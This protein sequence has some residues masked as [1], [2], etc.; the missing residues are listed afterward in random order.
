MNILYATTSYFPDLR[1]GTEICTRAL[2]RHVT[3]RGHKA[4]VACGGRTWNSPP[5]HARLGLQ[6]HTYEGVEVSVITSDP[7]RSK[8]GDVYGAWD[9]GRARAW[10][11]VLLD[12]R[13]DLLHQTGTSPVLGVEAVVEGRRLGIPSVW[14]YI[15]GGQTC[16]K[17]A[18]VDAWG[19]G[20]LRR[21]EVSACTRC[22]A[23]WRGG[24]VAGRLIGA[25]GTVLR[26]GSFLQRFGAAGR[27]LG[28]PALLEARFRAWER[29]VGA[30]TKFHAFTRAAAD[31]LITEGVPPAKVLVSFPGLECRDWL[32]PKPHSDGRP[33]DFGFVGRF[34][35]EKGLDVLLRAWEMLPPSA[36][37]TL[38]LLGGM[39]DA[40]EKQSV[41]R[42]MSIAARDPRVRHGGTFESD[43]MAR[44]YSQ[45]HVLVIPSLAFETGPLVVQEALA[46]GVV[47]VGSD[48][49]GIAAQIE[50]ESNGL[51]FP[52]GD[53]AALASAMAR[54]TREPALLET[55]RG[56]TNGH[57]RSVDDYAEEL[58]GLY[59]DVAGRR[60]AIPVPAVCT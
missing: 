52:M 22:L 50:H 45:L 36:P 49:G 1:Y 57:D 11:R 55:L 31:L 8:P 48:F 56:G 38:T 7:R 14:T 32:P 4:F 37:A 17:G 39:V 40:I 5:G 34:G 30:V 59:R 60:D 6:R 41:R 33:V 26:R 27:F 58:M 13:P 43:D 46:A 10:R 51:L 20:C 18:R 54:F 23:T 19:R 35:P 16:Q 53:A 44:T 25:A 24:G 28:T 21:Q 2:V 3:R 42:I 15:H 29:L 9:D 12:L 47:P